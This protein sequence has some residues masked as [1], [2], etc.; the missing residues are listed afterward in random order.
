MLP[1]GMELTVG[2]AF[3]WRPQDPKGVASRSPEHPDKGGGGGVSFPHDLPSGPGANPEPVSQEEGPVF[4]R[5][6]AAGPLGRG[7]V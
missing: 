1:G 3:P 4:F 6:C 7:Q 5:P 2:R